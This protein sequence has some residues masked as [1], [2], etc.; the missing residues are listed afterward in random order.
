MLI[1]L[2][3]AQAS[4]LK[5]VRRAQV[6]PTPP[7]EMSPAVPQQDMAPPPEMPP[8]EMAP[9]A[10][11]DDGG[12]YPVDTATGLTFDKL[13]DAAFTNYYASEQTPSFA[14]VMRQ[15][16]KE[17]AVSYKG[18]EKIC[19]ELI[20]AW[21]A[22]RR[23]SMGGGGSEYQKPDINMASM[24]ESNQK[25]GSRLAELR[26]LVASIE[27]MAQKV[28][29]PAVTR[30]GKGKVPV[31]KKV[32]GPDSSADDLG[33]KPGKIKQQVKPAG[34]FSSKEPAEEGSTDVL[35]AGSHKVNH[36]PQS[37]RGTRLPSTNMGRDTSQRNPFHVPSHGQKPSVR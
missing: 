11:P 13:I 20:E 10:P 29:E 31:G 37:Q 3:A 12:A 25:L 36:D 1:K 26:A 7:P 2:S 28:M 21:M 23:E 24:G 8:E 4:T 16:M 19:D 15:W 30:P 27:H 33:P 34:N 35:D 9:E 6:G 18:N 22:N 14:D 32:L 5:L 17:H